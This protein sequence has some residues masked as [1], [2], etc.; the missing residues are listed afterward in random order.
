MEAIEAGE[1]ELC[2]D[3]QP[4]FSL[5]HQDSAD[6]GTQSNLLTGTGTTL[7]QLKADIETAEAEMLSYK[8]DTGEPWNEGSIK[9]GIA[10]HPKLKRKFEELN[11]LGRINSTDNGMKGRI[12]QITYSSRLSDENDWYIADIGEGMKPVIKQNRQ[13]PEFESLEGDSDNGFM[14]KQF[15]Y[16]IDYRVGFGYGKFIRNRNEISS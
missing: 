6:S 12:S 5:S 11:T 8:D 14:R 1:T 16:G 9:I 13:N 4:F 10:C 2:Y 15:L 7:A 3:G